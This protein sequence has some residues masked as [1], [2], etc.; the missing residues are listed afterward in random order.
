MLMNECVIC[1]QQFKETKKNPGN[2]CPECRKEQEEAKK[3]EKFYDNQ[4]NKAFSR[5]PS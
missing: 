3:E 1:E 2:I 5:L 4:R